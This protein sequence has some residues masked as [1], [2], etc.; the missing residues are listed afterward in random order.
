GRGAGPPG[1]DALRLGGGGAGGPVVVAATGAVRG[2]PGFALRWAPRDTGFAVPPRSPAPAGTDG[3]PGGPEDLPARARRPDG[4]LAALLAEN[5][6]TVPAYG[7]DVNLAGVLHLT[8]T[9]AAQ[10][11]PPGL[12]TGDADAPGGVPRIER[13]GVT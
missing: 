1:G 13:A 6:T 7:A 11:G 5:A 8:A 3:T 9:S 4:P 2:V 12:L 10:D